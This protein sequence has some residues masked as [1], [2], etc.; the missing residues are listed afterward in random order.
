[1]MSDLLYGVLIVEHMRKR[2]NLCMQGKKY[3][4]LVEQV[5]CFLKD[6]TY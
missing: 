1:M 4:E 2:M 6:L 5:R 3:T